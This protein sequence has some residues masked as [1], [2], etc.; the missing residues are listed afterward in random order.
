ME[1]SINPF[2]LIATDRLLLRQLLI[3]DADK[4]AELR[5]NEQVNK[6]LNRKSSSTIVETK[7][8][9][10]QIN[11]NIS[12]GNSIYWVIC[13]KDNPLLIGIICLWNLIS[14]QEMAHIGYELLPQYHGKGLMH[15]ALNAVLQYGFK[16]IKLKI[17][18]GLTV[19]ANIASVALLERNGF[20]QVKA[21]EYVSADDMKDQLVFI[22]INPNQ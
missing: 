1:I 2:P 15:E 3:S 12:A 21:D 20:L 22:L 10:N 7:A 9:I 16:K 14:E 11:A 5:S 19:P 6:Y 13:L 18:R 4:L 8:F 17:I